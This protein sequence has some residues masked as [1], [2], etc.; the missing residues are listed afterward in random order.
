MLSSI[1]TFFYIPPTT[2]LYLFCIGIKSLFE[3]EIRSF[4]KEEISKIC[5]YAFKHKNQLLKLEEKPILIGSSQI[6][7]H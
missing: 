6:T 1:W 4:G 5:K 2:D 3:H 7:S